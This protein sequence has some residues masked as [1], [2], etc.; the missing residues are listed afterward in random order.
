MKLAVFDMDGVI[1]DSE[2]V[3]ASRLYD[4]LDAKSFVYDPSLKPKTAGGDMRQTYQLFREEIEGFYETFD[5]Y[6]SDR[7]AYYEDHPLQLA[8]RDI[9]DEGIYEILPVLRKDG[10][11]IA[12]ASSSS[13][14]HIMEVLENLGLEN[15]F[16]HIV[17]GNDFKMSKP[18]PDIYLH[19]LKLFDA[20]ASESFAVE[21]ST[22]GILSAKRAGMKVI[23]KRDDRFHYDQSPADCFI[24]ELREIPDVVRG[25]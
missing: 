2:P 13:L 5:A 1:I 21:D 18:S 24:D 4:F 8:W 11:Q 10:M 12:L 20:D 19:V 7:A 3:Y 9:V 22:K 6:I 17:S 25:W 14:A 16:D 15:A 23:A